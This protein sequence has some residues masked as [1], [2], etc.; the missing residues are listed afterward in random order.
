MSPATRIRVMQRVLRLVDKVKVLGAK[1]LGPGSADALVVQRDG[2]GKFIQ[3]LGRNV[4]RVACETA[5]AIGEEPEFGCVLFWT[6]DRDVNMNGFGVP[7]CPKIEKVSAKSENLR[8]YAVNLSSY[9][10]SASSKMR[11]ALSRRNSLR[12]ESSSSVKP[13]TPVQ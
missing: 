12:S 6:L 11:G 7:S 4:A 10:A 5:S 3:I 2:L 13:S 1:R 8:H 9:G